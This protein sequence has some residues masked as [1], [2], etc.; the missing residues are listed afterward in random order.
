M[1]EYLIH[2]YTLLLDK[3]T[4]SIDEL[5]MHQETYCECDSVLYHSLRFRYLIFSLNLEFYKS[6]LPKK[7]IK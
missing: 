1:K 2:V 4:E 7:W 3:V 5:I 6:L